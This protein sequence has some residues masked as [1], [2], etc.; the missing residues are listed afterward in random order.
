VW[1]ILCW[2]RKDHETLREEV[3]V[4]MA[5]ILLEHCRVCASE[6]VVDWTLAELYPRPMMSSPQVPSYVERF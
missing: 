5:M 2:K 3:E 1:L 6:S 4:M